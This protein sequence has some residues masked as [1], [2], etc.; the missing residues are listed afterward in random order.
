MTE[1][2]TSL[3]GI[4]YPGDFGTEPEHI[5]EAKA[6]DYADKVTADAYRA[7][8]AMLLAERSKRTWRNLF[9]LRSV[10]SS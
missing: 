4:R 2:Y 3:R 8:Y 10:T 9:G 5:R 7:G 1:N 6:Q